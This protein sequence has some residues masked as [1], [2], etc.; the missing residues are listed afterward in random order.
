MFSNA[1][2]AHDPRREASDQR[3]TVSY[4][5][6]VLEEDL[7]PISDQD[8]CRILWNGLPFVLDDYVHPS[9]RVHWG[10]V[11]TEEEWVD[12]E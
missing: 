10:Q 4:C 3:L 9:W 2:S 6:V 1:A 12:P 5:K 11:E 8:E 7:E